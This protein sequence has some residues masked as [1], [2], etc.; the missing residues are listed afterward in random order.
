MASLRDCDREKLEK[1]EGITIVTKT[2]AAPKNPAPFYSDNSSH[3]NQNY[4]TIA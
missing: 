4:R 1:M 2:H 3:R